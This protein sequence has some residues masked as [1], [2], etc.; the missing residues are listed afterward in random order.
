MQRLAF[1]TDDVP[2]AE[3]FAYWR[4]AI[5]E[6][7]IGV[8]GEPVAYQETPFDAHAD[9]SIGQSLGRLRYRS[10]A[11]HVFRRPREIARVGWEDYV[12][13]YRECSIGAWFSVDRRELLTKPGDILIADPSEP[14]ATEARASF[15]H[16]AWVFPR[17]LFEPHPPVPQDLRS[18]VLG[19]D[20]GLAGMAKAYLDALGRQIDTLDDREAGIVADN[21]CRLLAVVCGAAAGE[22]Q[23]AIRLA[24]LEEAKRYIG[25]HLADPE[26]T[27]ERA[28][29]ALKMSVRQLH[30]LFQPSGTSFAQYV[31]KRRLEECRAALLDPVGGRSVT[32]IPLGFGFNS[33]WTFNRTFRRAFGVTPSEARG[34]A[35][36]PRRTG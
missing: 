5:G 27:P 3:R 21:F 30:L 4:D 19:G 16:D 33:L 17:M 11:Y 29:A 2:E 1:S 6:G 15:D 24:R 28:A 32:D 13:V 25:L 23:E 18:F 34:R 26:M 10:D 14:L 7:F 8:S 9:L 36:A 12:F 35:A 20:S 22:H 31:L